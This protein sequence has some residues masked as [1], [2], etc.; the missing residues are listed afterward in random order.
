MEKLYH[1]R[2]KHDCF[3]LIEL[4]VVI[5]I[6]AILAAILLPALNSARE[7]GRASSCVSNAKQLIS[8]QLMYADAFRDTYTPPRK[9]PVA[10]SYWMWGGILLENGFLGD[11]KTAICPSTY[12]S[13]DVSET[14]Q[15]CI[16]FRAILPDGTSST[17]KSIHTVA[18]K[19]SSGFVVFADN[20]YG[21]RASG[22]YTSDDPTYTF[23]EWGW[24]SFRHGNKCTAAFADGHAGTVDKG[25]FADDMYD[26]ES[27]PLKTDID[28]FE[29]YPHY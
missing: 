10:G 19:N 28:V 7:R 21:S 18:I 26:W 16:G 6:I 3:T 11:Y 8:A 9:D 1:G 24:F 14:L 25:G 20:R 5:A 12:Q 29:Y 17:V 4:L 15:H 23:N 22:V 2:V 13:N 27:N